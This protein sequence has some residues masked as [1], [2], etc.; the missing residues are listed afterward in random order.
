MILIT[1]KWRGGKETV[2]TNVNRL[3]TWKYLEVV[4][5]FDLT[6]QVFYSISPSTLSPC[7][8]EPFWSEGV[9]ILYSLFLNNLRL[10]LPWLENKLKAFYVKPCSPYCIWELRLQTHFQSNFTHRRKAKIYKKL[11]DEN[12]AHGIES[13]C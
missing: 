3:L 2:N 9:L 1:N 11:R 7:F 10:P 4:L 13:F 8:Q 5:K 12:Y 6:F